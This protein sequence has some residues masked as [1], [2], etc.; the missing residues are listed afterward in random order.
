MR[1]ETAQ[2]KEP[3]GAERNEA[4]DGDYATVEQEP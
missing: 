2:S 3:G 1:S 4:K